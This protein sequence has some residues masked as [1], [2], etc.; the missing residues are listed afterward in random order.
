MIRI[1]LLHLLILLVATQIYAQQRKPTFQAGFNIGLNIA[2]ID[3]DAYAGYRRLGFQG[4]IQGIVNIRNNFY[5][6]TAFLYSQRGA[7]PSNK[8]KLEDFDN[9]ITLRLNYVE[10]PFLLNVG[11]GK[12][13]QGYRTYQAFG[14]VSIGRLLN[15]TIKKTGDALNFYPYLQIEDIRPEFENFDFSLLLGLQRNFNKNMGIYLKH[16]LALKDLYSPPIG[17]DNN[18][19]N[20]LEPF[21]FTFGATYKLY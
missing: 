18:P 10:V 7:K 14:G 17:D 19:F 21:H 9:F 12:K 5:L 8:E 1:A 4:G 15:T 20:Q 2:Q 13:A 16:T 6:S 3:G 11:I